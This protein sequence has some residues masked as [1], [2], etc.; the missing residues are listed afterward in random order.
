M[1][2]KTGLEFAVCAGCDYLSDVT[3]AK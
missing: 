2:S 3:S 1:N